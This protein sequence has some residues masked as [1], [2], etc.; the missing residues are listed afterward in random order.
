MELSSPKRHFLS[1]EMSTKG[2]KNNLVQ[3]RFVC[4]KYL[5]IARRN[6][7][8]RQSKLA[9]DHPGHLPQQCMSHSASE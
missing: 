8:H 2:N 5:L 4:T 1:T 3:L 7:L 9:D 6:R